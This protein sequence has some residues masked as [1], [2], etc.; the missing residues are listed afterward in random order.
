MSRVPR[1]EAAAP[2]VEVPV[3][4]V[5][6][7]ATVE[8]A[9]GAAP[10]AGAADNCGATS[11]A[12][13]RTIKRRE[14]VGEKK[15]VDFGFCHRHSNATLLCHRRSNISPGDAAGSGIGMPMANN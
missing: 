13:R 15:Y 6:G 14:H 11:S 1:V 7:V 3:G 4:G 12:S 2:P 5:L 9:V 10:A 8:E